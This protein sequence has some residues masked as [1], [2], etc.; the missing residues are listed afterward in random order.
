[1]KTT[2]TLS[3]ALIGTLIVQPVKSKDYDVFCVPSLDGVSTC[4]GWRGNETLT[5]V[6]ST[7]GVASCTSTAG[8]KVTCI[9]EPGG[10]TTCKNPNTADQVDSTN[11]DCT[12]IGNGSFRCN[13]KVKK[14][15][16]SETGIVD[17]I[18]NESRSLD[19]GLNINSPIDEQ[20]N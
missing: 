11:N 7:G 13:E 1:M 10:V 6:A 8:E 12:F 14:Y 15:K 4:N 2:F 20:M 18:G 5:C 9:E 19:G 16:E 17:V 3:I